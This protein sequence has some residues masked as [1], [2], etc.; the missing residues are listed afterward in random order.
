MGLIKHRLAGALK[1]RQLGG[2]DALVGEEQTQ[3]GKDPVLTDKTQ[4]TLLLLSKQDMLLTYVPVTN[5][6]KNDSNR[7]ES[8]R[9][10]ISPAAPYLC[11]NLGS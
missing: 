1:N 7:F 2:V 8:F 5:V 10:G 4:G 11:S 3:V 6:K 9:F